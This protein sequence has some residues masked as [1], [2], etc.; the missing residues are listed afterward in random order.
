MFFLTQLSRLHINNV[1]TVFKSILLSPKNEKLMQKDILK[2]F[3]YRIFSRLRIALSK[4]IIMECVFYPEFNFHSFI[5]SVNWLS[6]TLTRL[7][8]YWY[9][10]ELYLLLGYILQLKHSFLQRLLESLTTDSTANVPHDSMIQNALIPVSQ[11]IIT[12]LVPS[13]GENW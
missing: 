11:A 1:L 6:S 4:N 10:S 8:Y 3:C 2:C 7:W 13:Q 12:S 9:C 5:V